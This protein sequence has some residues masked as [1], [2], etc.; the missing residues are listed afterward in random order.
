[1]A[2]CSLQVET[3]RVLGTT[4]IRTQVGEN[5]NTLRAFG[6]PITSV[7]FFSLSLDVGSFLNKPLILFMVPATP[8]TLGSINNMQNGEQQKYNK[9]Y[10]EFIKITRKHQAERERQKKLALKKNPPSAEEYYID[11]SQIDTLV[12]DNL[13]E[14]PQRQQS[15]SSKRQEEKLIKLYG[16][17]ETFERIR[18]M[19][20]NID[21]YF[22][23]K[24]KELSP[25]YWPVIPINP[26]PYL[27]PLRN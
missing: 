5:C 7:K 19:E 2:L 24:C 4:P 23:S 11:I 21:G 13:V 15:N 12:Q 27:N 22:R 14:A 16:S 26:R 9:D 25:F 10:A 1:M 6:S 17:R 8:L 18:S 20:M 3:V